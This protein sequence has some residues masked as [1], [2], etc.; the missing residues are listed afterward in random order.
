MKY[1]KIFDTD[2]DYELFKK[3][4]NWITPNISVTEENISIKYTEKLFPAYLV[5][6]ENG[7]KGIKIYKYLSEKYSSN[8]AMLTSNE[9]IYVDGN[10]KL[11]LTLGYL[12]TDGSD[13]YELKSDGSITRHSHTGGDED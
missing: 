12:L 6:G 8:S 13:F 2:N 9:Q 10:L 5:T 1:T 4:D 7:E 11:Y 3:G